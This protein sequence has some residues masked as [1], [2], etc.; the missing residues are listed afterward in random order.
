MGIIFDIKRFAV[1][2]GPGIRTTVFLKG[3]PLS[4][5]WCHNPESISPAIC[6]VTKT[7]NIA[8]KIFTEV[9]TVGSDISVEVLLEELRKDKV[10]MVE[11]G[12]G[13]TFSGGEPLFQSDFLIEILSGCKA[14]QMHTTVD[15]SGFANWNVLE[16]VAQNTDLFLY[17]LKLM[18]NELHKKYTGVSNKLILE[19]LKKLLELDKKIRIRLPM[20]PDISF[21]EENINQT[22]A[23]LN[24]LENKPEGVDLLP[25]HTIATHK[26]EKF[27]VDNKMKEAKQLTK[28]DLIKTKIK[29]EEAGFQ[30]NIGG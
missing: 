23:Y 27:G 13:V 7:I 25:Y 12:G 9:E 20:I 14:E 8:E 28:N 17:D 4:C 1:H 18:D 11:S 5:I 16:K 29:F 21:T 30:V 6:K 2:D 26:Y 19:N 15:T 10:F 22:I 3:C 24:E